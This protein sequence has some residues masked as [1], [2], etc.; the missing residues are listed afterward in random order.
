MTL[1][2]MQLVTETAL[3]AT[4]SIPQQIPQ[5]VQAQRAFFQTGE[6][7]AI[8]F[9]MAQLE[10]LK[11]AILARQTEIFAA[12][13]TDLG[14][15]ALEACYDLT[16]VQE[17]DRVRRQLARWMQPHRVRT[18]IDV[19]PAQAWVQPEPVGCVLII[20]PWNL[21][22]RLVLMPLIGAIAA[23][24]CAILKPSEQAPATSRVV[25]ELVQ[26]TFAPNYVAVVEGDGLISQYLLT[27]KFDHIMFTGGT[28]IGRLVMAA[29][30]RHL[31]PVTLEL[32]GK[33]PC[34]VT[35]QANLAVA[36]RRIVWGKFVNAGQ[37]C[38]APDYLLVDRRV[39][40]QLLPLLVQQVQQFYG[41][42]PQ[43]NP[44]YGRIV[45]ADH[46]ARLVQLLAG[47][48]P[49]VGGQH[50]A[51]DRYIAPTILG[52]IDW[53]AP[54]MQEEIFG[55]ILPILTFEHLDEAIAQIN[56]RPKPLALYLFSEDV[57]EQAQTVS[58]T[59]SGAVVLN[60]VVSQVGVATLPFGGVGESGMGAY[61]GKH[62]FDTF[63]HYK[64]VLK[65]STWLDLA[66]RYA[67]YTTW[68]F[69]VLKFMV[70]GRLGM[71]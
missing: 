18:G 4:E 37:T 63:S 59:S 26:A 1:L 64:G 3:L 66:L 33:C 7:R 8:T 15:S 28:A 70:T 16:V 27:Q 34:I 46:H 43:Q 22:L 50:E 23:G 42:N 31:T 6:T 58:T 49:L 71:S 19:F 54:I 17:I 12:L 61:Q 51:S 40:D 55:P 65:R 38:V 21:P 41:E 32:G 30:A 68:K 62:S 13:Q 45:N 9:R 47:G 35:A 67:P 25:A 48:V 56:Q 11:A 69:Q 2:S 5:L 60:D 36:A 10:R 29:A 24:N 20:G 52:Q 53:D 57:R 44:D 39:K 14:R